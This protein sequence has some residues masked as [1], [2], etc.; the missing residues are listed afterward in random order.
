[1]HS[2]PVEAIW[3]SLIVRGDLAG[4]RSKAGYTELPL[5]PQTS[6][7]GRGAKSE[8]GGLRNQELGAT[9]RTE[10]AVPGGEV[11]KEAEELTGRAAEPAGLVFG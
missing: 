1:M 11:A 2:Q 10:P 8:P 3:L 9:P 5:R 7:T 6:Q 4:V